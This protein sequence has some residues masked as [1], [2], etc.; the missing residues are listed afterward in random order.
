MDQVKGFSS[1]LAGLK[2]TSFPGLSMVRVPFRCLSRPLLAGL[3]IISCFSEQRAVPE[4][5]FDVIVKALSSENAA[6]T[7]VSEFW[8]VKVITRIFVDSDSSS[9]N[10]N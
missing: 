6:T 1:I 3:L 5:N 10:A 2:E 4:S 8:L 7:Q 9:R